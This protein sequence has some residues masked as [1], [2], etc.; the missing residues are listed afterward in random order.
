MPE[1]S[2][3]KF[4][5]RLLDAMPPEALQ[6]FRPHL[7]AVSIQGN[8]TIQEPGEASEHVFFPTRGMISLVAMMSDGESVEIGMIGK[9]GMFS[10]SAILGDD[11]PSQ[12]AMVQLPGNALRMKTEMLLQ[13]AK[14]NPTL[15]ALLLRYAQMTLSTAA[16]T[17]AC[18]RLHLLE[19]RCARWLLSAHDRA[20]SDTFGMTHEFLSMMLGVRRPGVTVA[21]QSLQSSGL[22][23]YNHGTMTI[24]DRNGLEA[25][26]CECY[27]FLQ[28]EYARLLGSGNS[29]AEATA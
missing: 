27:R 23:T 28:D 20:G 12:R 5:N 11:T 13:E 7:E 16:Q 6:H 2:S 24:L 26:S 19:Q 8:Q 9:E 22:I 14:A 29:G 21:A 1:A 25:A 17:A 4:G 15:Q 3:T 18:N 10:V